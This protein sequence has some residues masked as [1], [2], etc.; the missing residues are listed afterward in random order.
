MAPKTRDEINEGLTAVTKALLLDLPDRPEGTALHRALRNWA[1]VVPGPAEQ[2][3]PDEVREVLAWV[4]A[5]SRPLADLD[6]PVVT[7]SVLDSLRFRLDGST[8]AVETLRRKR[9]VLVNAVQYGIE[10]G[11][12][13]ENPVTRSR[14]RPPKAALQVDPRVVIN[15]GQAREL[16]DAV[17]YVGGYRRARGRRL[18]G[19]FAGL[20]YAGL[21]PAEAVAVCEADCGLPQRGWGEVVLHRTLPPAGKKWTGT[22]QAHDV[23]GLKSRPPGD[24][25]MVPLPPQLVA[26]WRQSLD[27]FGIADDGRMFFNERGDIVG[28]T[29]YD[30][31]WHEARRLALPP[32]LVDTPLAARPYDL[33]HSALSTWL[34]GGADPTEVAERAGNTVE[35][36]LSYYAKCLYGRRATVNRIIEKLLREYEYRRRHRVIKEAGHGRAHIPPELVRSMSGRGSRRLRESATAQS[37]VCESRAESPSAHVFTGH[38]GVSAALQGVSRCS[39]R[40]GPRIRHTLLITAVQ[41]GLKGAVA[42]RRCPKVAGHMAGEGLAGGK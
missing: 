40:I 8:A 26:I 15:P 22:G 39:W 17:S 5:A 16:L 41:K 7:R 29:T 10:R 18:V 20:Y 1:F 13:A 6:D 2:D 4:A 34:N 36:L 14:W 30:R 12:F 31:A 27:T 21:R 37:T 33:R 28:A 24:A 3:L 9:K 38:S 23:R 19:F 35:V 32:H 25:R 42:P 11:L